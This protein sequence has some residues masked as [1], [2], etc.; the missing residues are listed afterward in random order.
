MVIAFALF[1]RPSESSG[2]PDFQAIFGRKLSHQIEWAP[3]EEPLS[4]VL[5]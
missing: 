4:F 1:P 5:Q 2:A 3:G